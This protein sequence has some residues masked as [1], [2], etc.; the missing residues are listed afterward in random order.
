MQCLEDYFPIC[1]EENRIGALSIFSDSQTGKTAADVPI[2]GDP[3]GV[4]VLAAVVIK[5][6]IFC[7]IKQCSLL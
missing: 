3:V 7:D 2:N 4:E 1:D 6:F 5:S